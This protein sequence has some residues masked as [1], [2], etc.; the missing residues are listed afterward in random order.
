MLPSTPNR[1]QPSRPWRARQHFSSPNRSGATPAGL[2]RV[3]LAGGPGLAA[4]GTEP[5]ALRPARTSEPA[6]CTGPQ[7]LT[8]LTL[9]WEPVKQHMA[10]VPGRA[11][12]TTAGGP[13]GEAPGRDS[14]P[15]SGGL[16]G[17]QS[18]EP[19][20]LTS[21][22][23]GKGTARAQEWA[24][25]ATGGPGR[26]RGRRGKGA[27]RGDTE[28]AGSRTALHRVRP[29][30]GIPSSC[31]VQREP[32]CGLDSW[33]WNAVPPLGRVAGLFPSKPLF[34]GHVPKVS[35]SKPCPCPGGLHGSHH[36]RTSHT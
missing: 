25:G 2:G 29:G 14:G 3:E 9:G 10:Q 31:V 33:E 34:E 4:C 35:S 23:P 22:C 16:P 15:G 12:K 19:G 32:G 5:V 7:D 27:T 21:E 20:I 17:A 18:C 30:E 28:S 6:P 1:R 26:G 24:A 11:A 8:E 36:C 13:G